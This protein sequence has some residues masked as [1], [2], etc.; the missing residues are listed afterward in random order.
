MYERTTA[1]YVLTFFSVGTV[2][3][4][5]YHLL[6]PPPSMSNRFRADLSCN[7][8]GCHSTWGIG[9][10]YPDPKGSIETDDGVSIPTG[11]GMSDSSVK[12]SLLY[13]SS[14]RAPSG[15]R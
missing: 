10:T 7:K 4:W 5:T 2:G 12:S 3:S 14:A 9:Q 1:E 8:A 11:K 13:V 15:G 6:P